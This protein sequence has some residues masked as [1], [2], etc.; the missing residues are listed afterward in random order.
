MADDKTY[1]EAVGSAMAAVNGDYFAGLIKAGLKRHEALA[2][3]LA[4]VTASVTRPPEMPH[5]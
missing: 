3:L 5:A 1:M 4:L 2:C